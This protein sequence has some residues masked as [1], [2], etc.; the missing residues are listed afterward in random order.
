MS[1]YKH[2]VLA[3]F[4]THKTKEFKNIIGADYVV[5][6]LSELGIDC[7]PPEEDGDTF[8]DNAKI[9]ALACQK[10]I[11]K[12]YPTSWIIADDSGI[13]VE[14]LNGEPG[15]YS[16]RY[17]GENATMEDNRDK[18]LLELKKVEADNKSTNRNAEFNCTLCCISE[19]EEIFFFEGKIEGTIAYKDMGVCGFG[20]DNIFIPKGYEQT[21]SILTQ[22]AKDNISHRKQA[23]EKLKKSLDGSTPIYCKSL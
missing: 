4:N 8:S 20:Y 21:F 3:T 13:V 12:K 19:T 17:A 6:D 15:I 2:I 14:A 5:E 9:K 23:I 22:K 11:R 7:E 10:L 1:S 18:L 16:S